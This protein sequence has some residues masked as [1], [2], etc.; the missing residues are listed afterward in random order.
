MN[1]KVLLSISF[2]SFSFSLSFSKISFSATNEEEKLSLLSKN[3]GRASFTHFNTSNNEHH[4]AKNMAKDLL[5]QEFFR[6]NL[7]G[8]CKKKGDLIDYSYRPESLQCQNIFKKIEKKCF[9]GGTLVNIL[10]NTQVYNLRNNIEHWL[11]AFLKAKNTILNKCKSLKIYSYDIDQKKYIWKDI[12]EITNK[13][14]NKSCK[15]KK[16]K[17]WYKKI[18]TFLSKKM[19]S[20]STSNGAGSINWYADLFS[21]IIEDH[22][23]QKKKALGHEKEENR[24]DEDKLED[25]NLYLDDATYSGTQI[26]EELGRNIINRQTFILLGGSRQKARSKINNFLQ[27]NKYQDKVHLYYGQD[28]QNMNNDILDKVQKEYFEN[29]IIRAYR[30]HQLFFSQRKG[31]FDL[32]KF[33]EEK[34]K[35]ELNMKLSSIIHTHKLPDGLSNYLT[36]HNILF[37][38]KHS[39]SLRCSTKRSPLMYYDLYSKDFFSTTEISLKGCLPNICRPY[40]PSYHYTKY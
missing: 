40:K 11:Q 6:K 30:R 1:T 28:L 26:V 10:K 31:P 2:I 38:N 16:K 9:A 21:P 22:F 27:E 35:D 32:K 20:E 5:D 15:K 8:N 39:L 24:F 14:S 12:A 7:I 37:Q 19:S 36:H 25:C 13:N 4:D 29:V 23:L 3:N 17:K 34:R 18:F 33:E